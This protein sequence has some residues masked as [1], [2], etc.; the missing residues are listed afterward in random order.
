MVRG[1]GWMPIGPSPL[2]GD[3]KFN[4]L[5]SSIAIHPWNPDI[6]YVGTGSGGLW[7]SINGGNTWNPLFDRQE[8][9]GV[10][11]P[12]ALAIDPSNP[13]IIYVG[14]SN[15]INKGT[16]NTVVT[17]PTGLYKS[18]DE[19]YSWIKLG[20]GYPSGNSGN[21]EDFDEQN[22][23]IIIVDPASPNTLYLASNHGVYQSVDGGVNWKRGMTSTGPIPDDDAQ[24]L[25]LD[26]SSVVGSR[27]LYA[28]ISSN[29]VFRSNDGGLNWTRILD[30]TTP[31][32]QTA[33]GTDTFGKVIVDIPPPTLTPNPAGVQIIYVSLQ[34]IG[35][36]DNPVGIFISKDQGA[37]WSMQAS[38]DIPPKTQDGYSFHMAVDPGSP[39][40]GI[41]DI[42]YVGCVGQRRSDDSGNKFEIIHGGIHADTHAWAFIRMPAPS[43]S[44]VYNGNDGGL[45][46]SLDKGAIWIPMNSGGIQTALF[47]N[48]S[49]RPNT[50]GKGTHVGAL[51]T[52]TSEQQPQQSV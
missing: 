15:R 41:N 36:S 11:E 7:K 22:I 40:D 2:E 18:T 31:A 32:V 34:R 28:G 23:N 9:L 4:G 14:S 27:I 13:R 12:G 39:G 1:R 43:P 5:V 16:P 44:V 42:I 52:T 37:S 45:F 47:Y 29:G 3:L 33:L 20:S 49:S 25:V 24:S 8:S 19:G 35:A 48:I 30:G 50:P 38:V 17:A 51:K 46:K 26:A 10:G 6:I 21:A